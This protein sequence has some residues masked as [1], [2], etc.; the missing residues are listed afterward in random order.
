M[1]LVKCWQIMLCVDVEEWVEQSN[2]RQTG[3]SVYRSWAKEVEWRWERADQCF[4]A[5]SRGT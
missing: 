5:E 2:E 4:V 1:V 3:N